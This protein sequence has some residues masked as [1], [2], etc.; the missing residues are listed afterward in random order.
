MNLEPGYAA[1]D[2]VGKARSYAKSKSAINGRLLTKGEI[3]NLTGV[4]N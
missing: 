1:T 4:K 2:A 3:E